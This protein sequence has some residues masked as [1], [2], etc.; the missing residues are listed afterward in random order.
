MYTCIFIDSASLRVLDVSK[1]EIGD[2]G[3]ELICE[4]LKHSST[5]SDLSM[6]GCGLS[7][8]GIKINC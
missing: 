5:L 2:H 8:Q 1:N 7:V 3:A 4:E 6:F